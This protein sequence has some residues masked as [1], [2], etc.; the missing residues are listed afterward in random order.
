MH[1]AKQR[2]TCHRAE[3]L[4]TYLYGEANEVD[5]RDFTNHLRTCDSCRSEYAVF[6]QLHDSIVTWR[7]DALGT[8]FNPRAVAVDSTIESNQFVRHERKLSALAAI[9]EFFNVSP[10]WLRAATSFAALLLLVFAV[11]LFIRWSPKPVET[12]QK[13]G[14]QR[15]Y[16]DQEVKA[17]VKKAVEKTRAETLQQNT[18]QESIATPP[19]ASK[20]QQPRPNRIQLAVNAPTRAVRHSLSRQEREQLAAD[21]RLTGPTEEDEFQLGFPEQ[22]RPN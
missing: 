5:A 9:K 4:V 2:P 19:V 7:N 18:A 14:E 21:L 17:E 3:D 1:E 10:L 11:T 16:T 22:E 6:N 12:A 20:Q 8:A 13:A 15:M